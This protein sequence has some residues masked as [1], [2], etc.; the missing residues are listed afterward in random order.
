MGLTHYFFQCFQFKSLLDD[1]RTN[2]LINDNT[3]NEANR[4]VSE[5]Q[6][7]LSAHGEEISKWL[8]NGL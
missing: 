5:N 7:W 8:L 2:N 6:Q 3:W 4:H 1:A